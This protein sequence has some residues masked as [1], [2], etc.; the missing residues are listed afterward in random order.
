M[1]WFIQIPAICIAETSF[2]LYK[3]DII[4]IIIRVSERSLPIK[5]M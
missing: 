2:N 4:I 5:L 3:Y 1:F